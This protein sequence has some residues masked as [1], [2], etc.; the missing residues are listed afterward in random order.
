MTVKE[1]IAKLEEFP[2]DR[3]VR[4]AE[5]DSDKGTTLRWYIG[6]ACNTEHQAKI[7]QVWFIRQTL[8]ETP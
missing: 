6:F 8:A 4:F 3:E 1:L 5:Y 7:A 2:Q